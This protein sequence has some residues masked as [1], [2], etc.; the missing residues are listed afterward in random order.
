MD[1]ALF[2]RGKEVFLAA[3]CATCH[4]G[5]AFTNNRVLPVSEV[6]TEPKR[7]KALEKTGQI[8]D[9]VPTLWTLDTP[10][11]IPEGAP[12]LEV[13]TDLRSEEE[14]LRIRAQDGEGGYKVKGLIGLR[15]TAPYLHLG[16]VAVGPDRDRDLGM[17]G[18]LL[19]GIVPD[20]A[21]S[22][23]ALLDRDLRAQVVAAN[24]ADPMLRRFNLSGIG[25]EFW[26]DE[27]AGFDTGA[28][29]ALIHYLLYLEGD[30]RP[31]EEDAVREE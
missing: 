21:N 15:F 19:R 30:S 20:P 18:T 4:S 28:Q 1:E 3:Q 5:P 14:S 27:A 11:P 9:P 24:R 29:Q 6:G 31:P 2:R 22:L 16:G 10:V 8:F 23:M 13:P 7:A 26:V 17:P 25:H 12:V